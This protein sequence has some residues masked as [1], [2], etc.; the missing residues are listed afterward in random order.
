MIKISGVVRG[1]LFSSEVA[2]SAFNDGYLNLSAYAKAIRKDVEA[3][4][5]TPVPVGS[6]VVLLSR[7]K[8]SG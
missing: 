2:L 8:K 4:A 5:K 6:I 7:L 1:I 3:R